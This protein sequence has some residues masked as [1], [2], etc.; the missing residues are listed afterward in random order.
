MLNR[1]DAEAKERVSLGAIPL[2]GGYGEDQREKN[3]LVDKVDLAKRSFSD[4]QTWPG[5]LV[6]IWPERFREMALM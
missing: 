2:M 5:T 6:G 4:L 3:P 1:V